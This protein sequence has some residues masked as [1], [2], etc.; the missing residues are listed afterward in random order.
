MHHRLTCLCCIRLLAVQYASALLALKPVQISVH[1]S[2]HC[3]L[4]ASR[5]AE[6]PLLCSVRHGF[7]SYWLMSVFNDLFTLQVVRAIGK[8]VTAEGVL[9]LSTTG[10]GFVTNSTIQLTVLPLRAGL[11]FWACGICS[12]RQF[13]PGHQA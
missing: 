12:S 4:Q 6:P 8:D 2:P 9:L 3:H 5:T 1:S 13:P 11:S 10:P 7:T